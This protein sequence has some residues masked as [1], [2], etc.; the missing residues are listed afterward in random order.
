MIASTIETI[1]KKNR[2]QSITPRWGGSIQTSIS[3]TVLKSSGQP[4][5][6]EFQALGLVGGGQNVRRVVRIGHMAGTDP[7]DDYRNSVAQFLHKIDLPIQ[8]LVQHLAS[9]VADLIQAFEIELA[10]E[11]AL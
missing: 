8:L 10:Q 4:D 5:G 1:Y 6:V 9:V 3:S 7:V 11:V 2:I